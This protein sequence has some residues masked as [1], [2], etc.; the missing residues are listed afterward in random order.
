MGIAPQT[1][2]WLPTRKDDQCAKE[3]GTTYISDGVDVDVVLGVLRVG[4]ERLDEELSQN[5]ADVLNL[6]RLAG[7]LSDPG[8]GLGPGLVEGEQTALASSLDELIGLR[9]EL[10]AGLEKPGVGDL[11][12]VQDGLDAG[13]LGEVQG[14]Q[15]RGRVVDGGRRQRAGLDD[16]S[17]GEVVVDDGL[18][19]GL[20]DRLG[21]HCG[22]LWWCWWEESRPLSLGSVS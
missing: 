8:L 18:A 2:T 19:I 16:G 6:L 5:T 22:W 15:S 13:V 17:T 21:G 20:G 12:L 7:A 14:G 10:G 3:K 1:T 11:G 4:N 9:D